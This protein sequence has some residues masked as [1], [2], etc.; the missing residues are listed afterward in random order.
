MCEVVRRFGDPLT[1]SQLTDLDRWLLDRKKQLD[2]GPRR[3][4][5]RAVAGSG[6]SCPACGGAH[7]PEIHTCPVE[8]PAS[9]RERIG[10]VQNG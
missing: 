4:L 1:A 3:G 2:A 7:S 8:K 10:N 5:V 9:L 6:W